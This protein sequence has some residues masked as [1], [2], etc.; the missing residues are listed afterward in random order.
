MAMSQV[1]DLVVVNV[2]IVWCGEDGDERGEPGRLT[3]AV[4][5]ITRT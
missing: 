3:L 2:E 4:H 5:A 1:T